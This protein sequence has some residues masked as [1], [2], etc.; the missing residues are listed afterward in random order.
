MA[1]G[2]PGTSTVSQASMQ[3]AGAASD[4]QELQQAKDKTLVGANG[5]GNGTT[6][7][8]VKRTPIGEGSTKVRSAHNN[9]KAFEK[10]PQTLSPGG[11]KAV[12]RGAPGPCGHVHGAPSMQKSGH[13]EARLLDELLNAA[14]RRMTL[15]IDWR[16]GNGKRSKMPCKAC[17]GMMCKV[18]ECGHEITLCNKKGKPVVLSPEHCDGSDSARMKLLKAIDG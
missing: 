17:Q 6:I 15:S 14:P 16:K 3:P 5:T 2:N 12:R 18:K 11:S 9:M 4:C 1:T 8:S 7:S 10:C 13:A